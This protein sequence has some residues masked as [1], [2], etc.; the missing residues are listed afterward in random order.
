MPRNNQSAG[1]IAGDA[2]PSFQDRVGAWLAVRGD[3]DV[4]VTDGE[5]IVYIE[6]KVKDGLKP[7][8]IEWLSTAFEPGIVRPDQVAVIQ[9]RIGP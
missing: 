1:G 3:P 9:G 2:G 7:S 5:R 8:Q 6:C 4:A